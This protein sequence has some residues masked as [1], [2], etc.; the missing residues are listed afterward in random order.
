MAAI[1]V[2]LTKR[3]RVSH[4]GFL[5]DAN[6]KRSS[7]LI[8]GSNEPRCLKWPLQNVLSL[9]ARALIVWK[10]VFFHELIRNG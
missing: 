6:L 7:N 8:K 10:L 9:G 3:D 5:F 1:D 4:H 2:C